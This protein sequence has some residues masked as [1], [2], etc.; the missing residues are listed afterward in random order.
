M[1]LE[2]RKK[3]KGGESREE[4]LALRDE[5]VYGP[6]RTK[7]SFKDSTDIN[8]ILKKAQKAGILRIYRNMIKP[9]MA[10]FMDMIYWKLWVR[11]TER[12]KYS[13]IC[14]LRS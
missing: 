14:L 4:L 2:I 10:S 3:M 6:G 13:R 8:K 1:S 12:M 7:Q 9:C 5:P 11:L